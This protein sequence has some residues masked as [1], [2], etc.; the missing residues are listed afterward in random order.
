MLSQTSY[1]NQAFPA[2]A[3]RKIDSPWAKKDLF[4]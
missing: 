2:W 3:A 4:G 1:E